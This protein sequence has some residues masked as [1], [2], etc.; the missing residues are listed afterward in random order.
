MTYFTSHNNSSFGSS[1]STFGS[2]TIGNMFSQLNHVP[3][4]NHPQNVLKK[5]G[6]FQYEVDVDATQWNVSSPL[7]IVLATNPFPKFKDC[8]PNIFKNFGTSTNE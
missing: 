2:T 3:I 7:N 8:L 6:I 4:S 5:S 1:D